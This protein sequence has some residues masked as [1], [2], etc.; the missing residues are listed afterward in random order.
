MFVWAGGGSGL[1]V[2]T[3]GGIV[4]VLVGFVH[5]SKVV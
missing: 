5:V 2:W 1:F 4:G 3:G